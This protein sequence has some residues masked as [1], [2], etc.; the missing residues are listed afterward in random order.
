MQVVDGEYSPAPGLTLI[1][2][3]G[4]TPGFQAVKIE[5]KEGRYLIASDLFPLYENYEK[6]IPS[7]IHVNLSD[8]Y[9]SHAK[10]TQEC[11]FILPG[12]DQKVLERDTYGS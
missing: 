10:A 12:H 1:P 9:A 6:K 2:L 4:H 3:P 5:T 11:D 8:W 7:G